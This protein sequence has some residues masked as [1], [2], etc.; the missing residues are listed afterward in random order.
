MAQ[1]FLNHT[2]GL[3]DD[4]RTKKVGIKENQQDV[5]VPHDACGIVRL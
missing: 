4:N 5:R 1:I 3:A 2:H